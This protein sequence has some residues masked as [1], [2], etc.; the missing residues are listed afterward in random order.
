VERGIG[1]RCDEEALRVVRAMPRWHPGK[2][3]GKP[4]RAMYVL[5]I[6]FKLI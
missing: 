5:P 3:N 4:V 6:T 1:Y 2:V